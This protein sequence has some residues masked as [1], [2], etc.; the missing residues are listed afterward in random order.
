MLRQVIGEDITLEVGLGTVGGSVL[1][2][3][4]HLEHILLNLVVNSRDAMSQG[5]RLRIATRDE[6]LAAARATRGRT[7]PAG[8]YVVLEVEDS[9][10]GMDEATQ[11]RLFEPF[12]TTKPPGSGT[13][14]GLYTVYSLVDQ[15]EGGIELES[16][17]GRGTRF[18]ILLPLH[19][20]DLAPP[21]QAPRETRRP[22]TAGPARILVVEDERLIRATLRRSLSEAGHDVL[23][24]ENAKQAL[25]VARACETAIDLLLSDIVL[26]DASG[27]EVAR[28]HSAE[29]PGLRVLF[30]SAYPAELLVQQGRI[31]PGT[32]T[33]EKPF[34]ER[35]LSDA[36]EEAL[37]E[38]LRIPPIAGP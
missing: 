15:L 19:V 1:A 27:T 31:R 5:G 24:A 20:G 17:P 33:L 16:E 21:A 25:E 11:S 2:N 12:F 10:S 32:R 36:I 22:P 18:R 35:A 23:V 28:I 14:L 3:P 29:I 9:G 38:D 13:G 4:T 30:M 37:G 8:N 34:D 7:L 26:P 6:T